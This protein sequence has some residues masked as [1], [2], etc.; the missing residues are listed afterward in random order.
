VTQIVYVR[1]FARFRDVF[2][3]DKLDI[4]VPDTATVKD[5]REQIALMNP[6]ITELL[7]R[8]QIAVNNEVV[9]DDASVRAG[10]ELALLPPVSGG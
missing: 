8:S 1:L 4:A 7:A 10:D 6:G 5:I 9:A 2:G 3:V